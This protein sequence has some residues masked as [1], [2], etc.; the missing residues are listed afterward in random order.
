VASSERSRSEVTALRGATM[1]PFT[2]RFPRLTRSGGVDLQKAL[3]PLVCPSS[4]RNVTSTRRS[5]AGAKL[6]RGWSDAIRAPR[7]EF[8]TTRFVSTWH[9]LLG[10][11]VKIPRV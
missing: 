10:A 11:L 8:K 7:N 1:I 9:P 3:P 4:T 6:E 5:E 2:D